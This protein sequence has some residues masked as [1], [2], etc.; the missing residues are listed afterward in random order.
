MTAPARLRTLL[1]DAQ[2]PPEVPRE[3]DAL[4]EL[5][6]RVGKDGPGAAAWVRDRLVHPKDAG[7]PYQIGELVWQT[8]QLLLEYGEL[9]LLHRLGYSGRFKRRYPPHRWAHSSEPVPW[10]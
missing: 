2:I 10:S 9:L 1:V 3:L 5:A 8:A 6:T 4:H 7:E